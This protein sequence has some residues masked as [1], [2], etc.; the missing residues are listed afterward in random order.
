MLSFPPLN[1]IFSKIFFPLFVFFV[2]YN[3]FSQEPLKI[4][5]NY[6]LFE[7]AKT[8]EPVIIVNDSTG[9][10][11]FNFETRFKTKFPKDQKINDF[12]DYIFQID[13]I[14]YFV[15]K[16]CG[17]VLKFENNTFNRIDY[18]FKQRNQYDAVPF[19]HNKSIHLWG[20]YGLFTF[21][22]F[23][24][25]FDF[26]SNEWYL[27]KTK[28]KKEV[29]PRSNA[30][31]FKKQHNLYVF[32]GKF[33]DG[34][35]KYK[36]DF[37]VRN[38]DLKTYTWS[39]GEKINPNL[40]FFPIQGHHNQFQY[41]NKLVIILDKKIL[42]I[43]LFEGDLKE[44]EFKNS[45]TIFHI[46]YHQ[47]NNSISFTYHVNDDLYADNIS[48][49]DF[50]GN[51]IA[52]EPLYVKE[53]SMVVV[54]TVSLFFSIIIVIYLSIRVYKKYKT[55]KNSLIYIVKRDTFYT[56]KKEDLNL[57]PLNK[58]VLKVFINQQYNFFELQTLNST[59][60]KDVKDD[61]YVTINKRR[62]RVLKDL[63]FELSNILKIPKG[64]VFSTR[65]S[66]LDKRVKEIRLNI[67]IRVK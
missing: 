18:S 20:G 51:M 45:K 5:D 11:G 66:E 52:D 65:N 56:Y 15:D 47:K 46:V 48:Y 16:G 37:Y 21:K 30:F 60:S 27:K 34:V 32:G 42:E 14:N 62:E 38:L 12:R 25:Y 22:K 63:K 64:E 1:K 4:D 19:I 36:T 17:I 3:F 6:L 29:I 55:K 39:R 58:E 43:D 9:Y 49:D 7:D 26:I 2:S 57:N 53:I 50:K 59:L 54:Y 40:P 23:T 44:Y 41:G 67:K 24:T 10:R 31:Y 61:N 35:N 28:N 33:Y 13:S 8:K